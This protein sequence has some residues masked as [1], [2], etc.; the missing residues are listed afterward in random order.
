MAERG[1]ALLVLSGKSKKKAEVFKKFKEKA[2]N[3]GYKYSEVM[4][5]LMLEYLGK[6]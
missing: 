2:E 1:E 5:R 3:E 4:F 6:K